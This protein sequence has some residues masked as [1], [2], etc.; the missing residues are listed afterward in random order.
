MW[1]TFGRIYR[2][3]KKNYS[4]DY[5]KKF[6]NPVRFSEM[7]ELYGTPKDMTGKEVF[8]NFDK[9]VEIFESKPS[10]DYST[11]RMF[12]KY[13][14]FGE[15]VLVSKIFYPKVESWLYFHR[16]SK[17]FYLVKKY[18]SGKYHIDFFKNSPSFED[19][20]FH[21]GFN[22]QEIGYV[23]ESD[24]SPAKSLYFDFDKKCFRIDTVTE[25]ATYTSEFE[26]MEG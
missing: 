26:V 21:N 20:D 9:L 10:K 12:G 3:I 25:D 19:I 18:N 15:L 13:K 22:L 2:M 14:I 6:G 23:E 8:S 24:F 7:K 1:L 5:E 16:N 17:R 11:G 4:K